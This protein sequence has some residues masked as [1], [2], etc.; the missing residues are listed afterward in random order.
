MTF[1][2]EIFPIFSN[3]SSITLYIILIFKS[4]NPFTVITN[5]SYIPCVIQYI[6]ILYL[7]TII[8]TPT[9]ILI[10]HDNCNHRF[11]LFICESASFLS[12]SLLCC[13]FQ[14]PRISDITEYVS[15]TYLTCY[16]HFTLVRMAII[17]KSKNNKYWKGCRQARTLLHCLGE[18][19]LV[20]KVSKILWSVLK[21]INI[22]SSSNQLMGTYPDKL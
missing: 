17:K 14:I 12:Y 3:L 1:T 9:P 11:Y 5:T 2:Y 8:C 10:L 6:L 13:I 21:K 15:L 7:I 20:Q 16:Y 4:Y 19:K 22:I 18:C